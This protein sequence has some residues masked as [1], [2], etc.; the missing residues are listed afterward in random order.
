MFPI[1]VGT[2]AATGIVSS[3]LSSF[4]PFFLP[5]PDFFFVGVTTGCCGGLLGDITIEV[6]TG[7]VSVA[8]TIG[9]VEVT[10]EAI[11]CG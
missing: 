9:A 7:E 6:V 5:P 1:W 3:G 4:F 10:N 2:G 11:G 8:V